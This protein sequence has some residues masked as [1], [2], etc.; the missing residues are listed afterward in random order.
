MKPNCSAAASF[1]FNQKFCFTEILELFKSLTRNIQF[2]SQI[3]LN[4][5]TT[6]LKLESSRESI[7]KVIYKADPKSRNEFPIQAQN[8]DDSLY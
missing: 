7:N 8:C 6:M 5:D 4:N 2:R 3:E 1:H